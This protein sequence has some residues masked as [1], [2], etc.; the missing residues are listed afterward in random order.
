MAKKVLLRIEL[1]KMKCKKCG[2][3]FIDENPDADSSDE[4]LGICNSCKHR[5]YFNV[6]DD[7]LYD[8]IYDEFLTDT[9]TDD[10]QKT[11]LIIEEY[12]K[13]IPL[14]KYCGG[15][16]NFSYNYKCLKCGN[17]GYGEFELINT[18]YKELEYEKIE[19]GL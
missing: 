11:L 15:K 7:K 10:Y 18:E 6:Y 5:Y 3:V 13:R 1:N 16:I 8:K 17:F 14:C 12:E 4:R 9:T 19:N 2:L